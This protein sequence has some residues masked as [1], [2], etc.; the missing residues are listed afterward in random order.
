MTP[1]I[2]RDMSR[3]LARH[4]PRLVRVQAI[5]GTLVAAAAFGAHAENG[6]AEP[7]IESRYVIGLTL[8]S[9][10]EYEG[11]DRR[12]LKIRPLWAY[13]HG[14]FRIST[15]GAS[16][17]MGFAS[18]PVGSGVSAELLRTERWKL[19]AALRF[20]SGRQSSD[21]DH[22]TGLPDIQR[23]LRGRFFVSYRIDDEWG[24]GAS[25]SQDL[26][27]RQGGAELGLRL[28]YR[29]WLSPTTSISAGAGMTLADRSYMSTYFGVTDMQSA[30][31]GLPAYTPGAG[32]KT[33]G[34]GIGVMTA[35]TPRWIAFANAGASRLLGDAAASPISRH[36]NS[37]TVSIG[38]AYRCCK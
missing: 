34:L 27:G 36:A 4:A 20:D 23:T 10:P 32:L 13:K 37:A 26:L 16:A 12:V 21:S 31:S 1:T 33:A 8:R 17:V 11:S 15:S 9:V 3:S 2:H 19:G 14:R 25:I 30:T 35:L 5:L 22:L 6:D 29:H 28:G 7:A 18:D 24:A 38:L